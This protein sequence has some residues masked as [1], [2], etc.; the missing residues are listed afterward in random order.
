MP[1]TIEYAAVDKITRPKKLGNSVKKANSVKRPSV[2]DRIT[3]EEK[4]HSQIV[5]RF[6][7]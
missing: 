2:R 3:D 7:T 5:T 4:D 6:L 1:K